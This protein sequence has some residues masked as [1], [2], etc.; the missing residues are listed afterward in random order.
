MPVAVSSDQLVFL[1]SVAGAEAVIT[2]PEAVAKLSKDFYWYSPILKPLLED[3]VASAVV[4]IDHLEV[5]KEVVADAVRRQVPIVARG[6]GTGNYGQC[7]PLH[8]GLVIDLGPMD[9]IFSVADGVAR[10]EPGAK[11]SNIE[12]AARAAGWE[13]RCL[14]STWAKSSMGG[15]L[16]GGSGGI[17]SI[18]YGMIS[19]TD[20]MKS[21]T[22][23]TIE[24]EP[25]LLRFEERDC[26]PA[27][28][29][30]GTTGILVEVEMR[31]GPRVGYDQHVFVSEDWDRLLDWTDGIARDG[32]LRRRLVTQ[33]EAPITP[34]FKPLRKYLPEG[35]HATFVLVDQAQSAEL[36]ERAAAAGVRHTH[37]IPS[38]EPLRPPFLTDYTWNHTTLWAMKADPSI[39]YLQSGF[40][41]DFREQFKL[42]W[43][44]FPGE[45][46][47]HLEWVRG[48]VPMPT[49]GEEVNVGGIP[50]VRYQSA[51]RLQEI[52]DYCTEIGV[53]TANP[54]TPY[55]EGG[56]RHAD[57][58]A[59]HAF[60]S[61][62]DPTGILNPGKMRTFPVNPFAVAK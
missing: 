44:R 26:L 58:S 60:K 45:I 8:G 15:F 9:K 7:I 10:V 30:Y 4:R 59:K 5:L 25:Q 12:E 40:T 35:A 42:L 47:F 21:V 14:P 32:S 43:K 39:T 19:H 46:L 52:I 18:T 13:L 6:A 51:E 38:R 17:G 34:A 61:R 56:G 57:F 33:F 3:K 23:L 20:N 31:L 2:E 27:L 1:A 50:L 48:Q 28:H 62:T 11:L 22:V 24:A 16:S 55:L 29:T 53:F 37:T 36:L 41:K 54:H 49:Y